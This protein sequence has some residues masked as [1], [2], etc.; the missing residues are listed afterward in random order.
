MTGPARFSYDL[1]FTRNLGWLNEGEQLALRG[2]CVAI[3]GMGGVGGV[4]L[5]TL[6]R[7]GIG[8]F[9]IADFDRFDIVNFNRQIGA[10]V[11]TIGRPKAA[12]AGGNGARY[13]S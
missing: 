13:Q 7:L 1:A 3:A 8:Q 10:T 12:S 6:A 2:K 5:L 4:E 9:R 11:Q